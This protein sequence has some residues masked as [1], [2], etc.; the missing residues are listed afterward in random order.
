M[1]EDREEEEK[2]VFL[3]VMNP[4][5]KIHVGLLRG[6]SFPDDELYRKTS[7]VRGC[8]FKST[9]SI[10]ASARG[11]ERPECWMVFSLHCDMEERLK[12][13]L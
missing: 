8:L 12:H 11:R 5:P 1:D 6:K 9:L 10:L 13:H 7:D 4:N 2:S 3:F